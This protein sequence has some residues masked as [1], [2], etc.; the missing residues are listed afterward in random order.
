MLGRKGRRWGEEDLRLKGKGAGQKSG[1]KV[2]EG[3]CLKLGEESRQ[4]DQEKGK[5]NGM[6]DSFHPTGKRS[7]E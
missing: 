3:A 1:G 7:E 6:T 2:R 4:S 5:V